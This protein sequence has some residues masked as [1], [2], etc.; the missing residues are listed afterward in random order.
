MDELV[1][2]KQ[3]STKGEDETSTSGRSTK[4]YEKPD[5]ILVK[6]ILAN[7]KAYGGEFHV[8]AHADH[9]EADDLPEEVAEKL[10]LEPGT[11]DTLEGV[12]GIEPNGTYVG[13]AGDL[14][15]GNGDLDRHATIQLQK[16]VNGYYP[17]LIEE[18]WPGAAIA[19]GV[20]SS[21]KFDDDEERNKWVRIRV[22]DTELSERKRKRAEMDVGEIS[23]DDYVAWCVDNEVDPF[24]RKQGAKGWEELEAEREETETEE[25][26]EAD[27]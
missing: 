16:S 20:G 23:E 3:Y 11:T 8:P 5:E 17:E 14:E 1:T 26:A 19:V 12:F 21:T 7:L 15:A 4:S 18:Q 22:T 25:R 24:P 9:P 13:T 27:D 6:Y 10:D 2:E